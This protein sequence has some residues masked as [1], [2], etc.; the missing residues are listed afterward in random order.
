MWASHRGHTKTV[1]VLLDH[2]ADPNIVATVC[3]LMQ[4]DDG[5]QTYS[6][7]IEKVYSPNLGKPKRKP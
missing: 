7:T 3:K 4:V 5:R 6:V 1:A 2:G